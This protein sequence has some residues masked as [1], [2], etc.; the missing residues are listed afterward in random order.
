MLPPREPDPLCVCGHPASQHGVHGYMVISYPNDRRE[1]CLECPNYT[2][3]EQD[4]DGYPYKRRFPLYAQ[5]WHRFRLATDIDRP[6]P[7]V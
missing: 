2:V 5:A 3:S 7:M 1:V 6:R 4:V